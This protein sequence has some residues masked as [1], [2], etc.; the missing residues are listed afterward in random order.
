M[1]TER[2][3]TFGASHSMCFALKFK[4]ILKFCAEL[5]LN[6]L[7]CSADIPRKILDVN[8]NLNHS[9]MYLHLSTNL[10]LLFILQQK[11]KIKKHL[12]T[13]TLG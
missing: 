9:V 13:V 10:N 12:Y 8:L 6:I 4:D 1:K 5:R 11:I 7:L 2:P 3:N